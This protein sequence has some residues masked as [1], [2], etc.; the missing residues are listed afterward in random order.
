MIYYREQPKN[1]NKMIFYGKIIQI[2]ILSLAKKMKNHLI[3]V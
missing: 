3:V 2:V 1:I